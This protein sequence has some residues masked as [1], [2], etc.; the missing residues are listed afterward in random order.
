MEWRTIDSAP[1]DGTTIDVWIVQFSI[2]GGRLIAR[3]KGRRIP[4]AWWG[5]P[6]YGDKREWD[7]Q[8]VARDGAWTEPLE[9]DTYSITHWMPLPESPSQMKRWTEVRPMEKV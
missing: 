9:S 1:K 6:Y 7:K 4:D 2:E 3:D 5:T 8:W